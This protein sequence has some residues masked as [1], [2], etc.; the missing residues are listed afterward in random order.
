MN[1]VELVHKLKQRDIDI[2]LDND[3]LKLIGDKS[4]L[5]SDLLIEIRKNKK[6]IIE[7]LTRIQDTKRKGII[8]SEKREY[9]PLSSAQKRL[10]VIQAMSPDS[11]NYNMPSVI[12]L[13]DDIRKEKLEDIFKIIIERHESLRSTFSIV[14]GQPVQKINSLDF[15]IDY[16]KTKETDLQSLVNQLVKPFDLEKGPL[17]RASI[18]ESDNLLKLLFLDLHHIISDGVTQNILT[19]EFFSLCKNESIT[20][21]SLHYKDYAIWQNKVKEKGLLKEQEKYWVALYSDEIDSVNF[22]ADFARPLYKNYE[23]NSIRFMLNENDSDSLKKYAKRKG[24]TLFMAIFSLFNILINKLTNQNDIIVGT[25]IAGRRYTDLEHIAGIFLNTL[26]LRNKVNED[27][28]FSDFLQQ[29]KNKTINAFDNQDYP[30]EDLLDKI[31]IKRDTG[32]NPLFDVMFNLLNY[33]EHERVPEKKKY[34]QALLPKSAKFD[35]LLTAIDYG[36]EIEFEFNYCTKLFKEETIKKWIEYFEHIVCQV[37]Q[38]DKIKISDIEAITEEDKQQLLV[39]HNNTQTNYPS[40]RLIHSFFEEQVENNP[41]NIAL[42][43]NSKSIT[44]DELNKRANQ[45]ARVLRKKS[46]TPDALVGIMMHRSIDLVVGLFGI[47]KAGGAYLP[48]DPDYPLD[49]I[50]YILSNS[51]TK[52]LIV[53]PGIKL[54]LNFEGYIIRYDYSDFESEDPGNLSAINKSCDLAY[55]I[56]TSGSTGQPKGVMIEHHSVVNRILWMQKAYP[57]KH[58][59]VLLQKT[60]IVFDVSVWELFW[61]SFT[62]ASLCLLK[63]GGEKEPG[64]IVEAIEKNKVTTIH[65]VPSMLSAFMFYFENCPNYRALSSLRQ[66]FSSGEALKAEYVNLF[67]ELINKNCGTRLINLYGPTEAT[68][69][70]SYYECLFNDGCVKV[71]I[72]KPI[73]NIQL[74]VLDKK[75]RLVPLGVRGELCIAGV[76]LARGYL[77]NDKLTDEKFVAHPYIQGKRLYR[78]GDIAR[79]MPDGNV[80]YLG[81]VDDQVKIRGFRIELGE[82]EN[83]LSKFKDIK[84]CVVIL[85]EDNAE[86]KFLCAYYVSNTEINTEA[87][88]DFLSAN[89]PDYMLPS[90]FIKIDEIPLTKNGKLNKKLLP[91]PVYKNTSKH[92]EPRNELEKTIAEIWQN[93]LNIEKS[94]INESYFNLGGDSIKAIKL[95]SIINKVLSIKLS[96]ADIYINDTIQK[97]ANY[98]SNNNDIS[99]QQIEYSTIKSNLVSLKHRVLAQI[100]LNSD[101]EDLYPMSDIEKGMVFHTLKDPEARLYHDQMVH[102]WS[103]PNFDRLLFER[104]LSL[105]VDKHSILRTS[106]NLDKYEEPVQIINKSIHNN[107]NHFDISQLDETNQ[108]EFVRTK[109]SEDLG[110]IIDINKAPLWRINTFLIDNDNIVFLW[111]FH[112]A[113]IDGWSNALFQTELNNIYHELLKNKN[114]LPLKLK[115]DYKDFI[116]EH[117]YDKRNEQIRKFWKNE[118]IDYKRVNFNRSN[119][120]NQSNIGLVVK[121]DI[122][123]NIET[124]EAR[125]ID[126][127]AKNNNVS[128]KNVIMA[129]FVYAIKML[130]YENDVVLGM[131]VHTRPNNEDGERLLGC[132]LNTVP[133]RVQIPSNIK[134]KDYVS[135]INNKANVLKRYEKLSLFEIAYEIG[136]TTSNQNP[137]FDIIYNYVNFH[138]YDTLTNKDSQKKVNNIADKILEGRSVNN[139]DIVLNVLHS[140]DSINLSLDY[141][142]KNVD[143]SLMQQMLLYTRNILKKI[144]DASDCFINKDEILSNDERHQVLEKY[145]MSEV[146]YLKGKTIH[147][148]FED[149]VKKTPLSTAIIYEDQHI[150][151]QE[152]NARSN[153]VAMYLKKRG[154]KKED[155]VALMLNRSIEMVTGLYGILKSGCAYLPIDPDYPQDRINYML[156]NSNAKILITQDELKSKLSNQNIEILNIDDASILSQEAK[157]L[158]KNDSSTIAYLIYTSGSTGKPKG[159][160]IEHRNVVNFITGVTMKIPFKS[161]KTLLS[162]TTISFDIFVLESLLALSQGVRVVIGSQEEQN[163][164]NMMATSIQAHDVEMLQL[165][166]SRLK[167]IINSGK[168]EAIFG[169]VKELMVGGEA[170]P[171]D[172]LNELKTV[173]KGRI[174]NM[175]GPTETTVWSTIKELTNESEITLGEPIANT[176]IYIL[177]SNNTIQP[178]GAPGEL[179]IGGEGVGRG[180]WKLDELTRDKFIENPYKNGARIYKTGDLARRRSDG[181]LEFLDRLDHQ[182]K[183]RGYR[184][185]LGEIEQQLN[186]HDKIRESLVI[187]C[188]EGSDKYLC[189]YIVTDHDINNDDLRSYLLTT[190][191]DYMVPAYYVKLES[192]PLTPN[193]KIN[194][195]ALPLPDGKNKSIY[196]PPQ[197]KNE[198]LLANIWSNVLKIPVEKISINANFFEIGGHSLNVTLVI[199]RINEELFVTIPYLEF[200]KRPTISELS[201][202]I[203][204]RKVYIDEKNSDNL[205]LLKDSM[206][207]DK[208]FFFIHAGSGEATAYSEI[209]SNLDGDFNF[210]GFK[211]DKISNYTPKDLSIRTIAEKYTKCILGIQSE[212]PY[213]LSGWCVGGTIAFEIARILE[214]LNKNVKYLSMINSSPPDPESADEIE[215]FSLQSE[216]DL[217]SG[218]LGVNEN[219]NMKFISASIDK[220]WIDIV[221]YLENNFSEAYIRNKIP[222]VIANAIPAIDKQDI[223]MLMFYT[224]M[225]RSHVKARN[226]YIPGGKVITRPYFFSAKHAIYN[227]WSNWNIYSQHPVHYIEINGDHF[228]IMKTP[229]VANLAKEF[230]FTLNDT[231]AK[232]H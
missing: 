28:L 60:P 8:P 50:N 10:F 32:R 68:V 63:P 229:D 158:N 117:I 189:T 54:D 118:L 211:A 11:I 199:K 224:N 9:Y 97:L 139:A 164:P 14:N 94:S 12:L 41:A 170:F 90:Y 129:A 15:K 79:L 152:L 171:L 215:D 196:V 103:I 64:E 58:E 5:S 137:I 59:D 150:N 223:K 30:F 200:F 202:Y 212:G 162:L 44:Y 31:N 86:N 37:I 218:L 154:T 230:Q 53:D 204:Q 232:T 65:F 42:V 20:P 16:Y 131:V 81:R 133:F 144:I 25:P 113:I 112:H 184:I 180:Y 57:I 24:C 100:E 27:E 209:C 69:D 191:P 122:S 34:D 62:G 104:A 186:K 148:L 92:I 23:G 138:I 52:H 174:F 3:N 176:Q 188:G 101:I 105:M 207:V 51:N 197:N 95:I 125:Q 132:F 2:Y 102:K 210:W 194:R 48:I 55:V 145:N 75:M 214:S 116:I 110:N 169:M 161:G 142:D 40:G 124:N 143:N 136:E 36:K 29:V 168:S 77:N 56:Y 193:G 140:D 33:S 141:S 71:P 115:C 213:Y 13:Q 225:L 123:V 35:L 221:E 43:C 228:S 78:T 126:K 66:V 175:Y 108:Y 26:A 21:L 18:I 205:V 217:F 111:T 106:F 93:E 130:T 70:V 7:F 185:E 147:E 190:L 151:Y 107:Y 17:I 206:N 153:Q 98:I 73:D 135:L 4:S 89:L 121:K 47:L 19:K 165:T 208:H 114:Y 82:I 159:I 49:R 219:N 149:Q 88:N 177:D 155:V 1:S 178:I 195:K 61:W 128:I 172:L 201:N 163:D 222:P 72:G 120:T 6:E 45:L 119:I 156:E 220:L 187:A 84:D 46:V 198:V 39:K 226:K 134:W 183:I 179:C 91:K 87:L 85:H 192:F 181:E 76:G 127:F 146:P 38:N 157:N 109:I 203:L 99:V 74:Y 83:R 227:N 166:P 160:I 173:Y 182:I 80:E 216:L 167:M 96:I 231:V 67:G 22:P